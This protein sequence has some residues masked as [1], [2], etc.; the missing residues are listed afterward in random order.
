M[1]EDFGV[2]RLHRLE[3]TLVS[4]LSS[5]P[6]TLLAKALDEVLTLWTGEEWRGAE[7]AEGKKEEGKEKRGEVVEALFAEIL[8]GVGDREKE[9]AMVWWY[10]HRAALGGGDVGRRGEGEGEEGVVA[11]L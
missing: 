8:E 3:L 4:T 5:L 9:Y 7:E 1:Q 10:R 6:L 2:E 11:R